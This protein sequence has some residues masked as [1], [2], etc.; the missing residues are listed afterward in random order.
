LSREQSGRRWLLKKFAEAV[1]IEK[2]P[3]NNDVIGDPKRKLVWVAQHREAQH[4]HDVIELK[5]VLCNMEQFNR[6]TSWLMA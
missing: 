3:Q 4:Y 1:V 2:S 6:E 5:A